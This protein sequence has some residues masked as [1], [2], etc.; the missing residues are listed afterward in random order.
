MAYC[1]FMATLNGYVA[2]FFS[3]D[4]W[5]SFKLWGF[6]FPLIFIVGQGF[7]VARYLETNVETKD[8]PA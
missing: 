7:Y 6:V 8:T 5:A 4:A 2:L 3:T 1:L